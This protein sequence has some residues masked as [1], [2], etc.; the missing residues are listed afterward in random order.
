M[1]LWSIKSSLGEHK[2]FFTK[3]SYQPQ[4]FFFF[5]L[6]SSVYFNTISFKNNHDFFFWFS[7]PL[8]IAYREEKTILEISMTFSYFPLP[9]ETDL[10]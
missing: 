1:Y 8:H 5:F 3:K 4:T 7:N 9:Q 6:N 2:G 10:K